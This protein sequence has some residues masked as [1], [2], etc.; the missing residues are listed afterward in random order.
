MDEDKEKQLQPRNPVKAIVS[1]VKKALES[2]RKVGVLKILPANSWVA[3]GK[4]QSDPRF[5]YYGLVVEYE[6]IFC[7]AA[8]NLGKSIFC[9]Q[10]A[11]AIALVETVLYI[12]CELSTKQ[13]QR[14]SMDKETG[15]T[16]V[17][18]DTLLR[19]EIDKSNLA[20]QNL[21]DTIID[22]LEQA[23]KD[24]IRFFFIDNVSY[25][26]TSAEKGDVAVA[27]M[28]RLNALKETYKL[29]IVV[30]A[31]SPKRDKSRPITEDDLYGSSRLMQLCD[32]AFAIGASA[33]D[34]QLRYVKTTKYR[35]DEYP[36]PANHVAVYRLETKDSYTQFTFQGCDEEK[37]HL[38]E[39]SAATEMED[40]QEFVDLSAQGLS[41]KQIADQTGAAKSTIHRKLKKALDMGMVPTVTPAAN[42]G[43][44][45]SSQVPEA[46]NVEQNETPY[47]LP[48]KDEED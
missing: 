14:R 48:F 40:M 3:I 46:G 22:S 21:A 26:C 12:D 47:R 25:I 6:L 13:Y 44:D 23:A 24:G 18:P 16:H 20:A 45:N 29:T 5:F 43:S 42:T 10:I 37:N 17:F 7:Y 32:S 2:P 34:P 19:A 28:H 1:A 35:A 33:Q 31:H 36:Y 4:K 15:S 27:F 9:N 38:K 30:V 41:L 39:K 11:A 8:S